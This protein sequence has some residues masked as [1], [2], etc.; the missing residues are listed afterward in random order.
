MGNKIGKGDAGW[1]KYQAEAVDGA[2]GRVGCSKESILGGGS[3]WYPTWQTGGE[4]G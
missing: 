1:L 2:G 3:Y 4:R